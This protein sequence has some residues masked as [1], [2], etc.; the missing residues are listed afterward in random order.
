M[1]GPPNAAGS[2]YTNPTCLWVADDIL[3]EA[4]AKLDDRNLAIGPSHFMRPDLDKTVGRVDLEITRSF[5]T[6]RSSSSGK[7]RIVS[8][9]FEL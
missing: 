7:P 5:R 9:E 1:Q 2:Q 4:N 6:S 3:D 8:Q